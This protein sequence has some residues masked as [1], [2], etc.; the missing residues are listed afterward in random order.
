M[1]CYS[2]AEPSNTTRKR[3]RDRVFGG[4]RLCLDSLS[5]DELQAIQPLLLSPHHED[6][7]SS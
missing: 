2:M 7:T 5:E 3:M 1:L 4:A 6:P